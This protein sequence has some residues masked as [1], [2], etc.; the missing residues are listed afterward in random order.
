MEAIPPPI[1]D[2]EQPAKVVEEDEDPDVVLE[3][4]PEER[5]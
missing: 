2:Q 1:A 5:K 4:H 3:N